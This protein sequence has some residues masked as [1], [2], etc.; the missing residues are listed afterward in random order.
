MVWSTT[1]LLFEYFHE[2]G[3]FERR[4]GLYTVLRV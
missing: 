1:H 4:E 2:V 3:I